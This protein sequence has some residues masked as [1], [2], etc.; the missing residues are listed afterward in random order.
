MSNLL[1]NM[2]I[3]CWHFQIS[4]DMPF[5]KFVYNQAHIGNPTGRWVDLYN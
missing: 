5:V 1:F 2:R 4:K 3:G